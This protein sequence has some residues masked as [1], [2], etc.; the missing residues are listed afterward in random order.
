MSGTR[1]LLARY[2]EIHAAQAGTARSELNRLKGLIDD[3]GARLISSFG[4]IHALSVRN[5]ELVRRAACAP[6]IVNGA[7]QRE[8]DAVSEDIKR[9]M[10]NAVSALQF[11]D[12]A[13][14]L[15]GHAVDRITML[16]RMS[17]P[18][19]RIPDATMDDLL[20]V[21]A[22]SSGAVRASAVGQASMAGGSV[23]LF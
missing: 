20:S 23:D 17:E 2:L 9:E 16:E 4:A 14:Q 19:R 3:A 18:L 7:E 13:T 21:I 11:Q 10:E 22:A 6:A 1:T 15:V 5:R 8:L 12:M